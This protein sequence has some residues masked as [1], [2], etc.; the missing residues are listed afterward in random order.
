MS[1]R[2]TTNPLVLRDLLTRHLVSPVKW[3][4]SLRAMG[5]RGIDWFLEAGPRDVLGKLARRAVPGSTVRQV[6]SPDEAVTAAALWRRAA[7]RTGL[8]GEE[9]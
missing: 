7:G 6:G 9:R 8:E 4:A 3:E 2:P 1:A 5:E